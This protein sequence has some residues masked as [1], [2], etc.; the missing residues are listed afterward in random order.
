MCLLLA[1]AGCEKGEALP[2][3]SPPD[4]Q[5]VPYSGCFTTGDWS[6]A[7]Y[8]G[9]GY[10]AASMYGTVNGQEVG[11]V[12]YIRLRLSHAFSIDSY[13]MDVRGD[14]TASSWQWHTRCSN[15]MELDSDWI[16]DPANVFFSS[17]CGD[18]VEATFYRVRVR[19]GNEAP[20]CD[21]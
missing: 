12:Q 18:R 10:V 20:A 11:R 19:A 14:P 5:V 21:P 17:G 4:A 16:T 15:G 9:A 6:A 13:S 2:D 3:A 7:T 1:G 8:E